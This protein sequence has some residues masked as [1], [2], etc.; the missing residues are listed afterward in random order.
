MSKFDD[1]SDDDIDEYNKGFL[2]GYHCACEKLGRLE[3]L[4]RR[5]IGQLPN[6]E[7]DGRLIEMET[8]MDTDSREVN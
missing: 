4:H 3:V 2:A 6:D 7:H 8:V 5:L 1:M